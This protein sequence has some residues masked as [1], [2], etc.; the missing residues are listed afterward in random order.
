MIGRQ[1]SANVIHSCVDEI[2]KYVRL[3][4]REKHY[5]AN[6]YILAEDDEMLVKVYENNPFKISERFSLKSKRVVWYDFWNINLYIVVPQPHFLRDSFFSSVYTLVAPGPQ[7]GEVVFEC[8]DKYRLTYCK[9]PKLDWEFYFDYSLSYLRA[10]SGFYSGKPIYKTEY[11]YNLSGQIESV[12]KKYLLNSQEFE[13]LLGKPIYANELGYD[14]QSL[15]YHY[16][17]ENGNLKT[18]SKCYD[19]HVGY[20]SYKYVF[21]Y[22]NKLRIISQ[23]ANKKRYL[24]DPDDFVKENTCAITYSINNTSVESFQI[25]L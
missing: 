23:Y 8:D 25:E 4:Q 24:D 13:D 19:I 20:V 12:H 5:L 15:T 3:G 7:D 16:S 11:D 10:E 9:F 22:S 18:V 2:G 21:D 1:D 17:Y 14:K 6:N